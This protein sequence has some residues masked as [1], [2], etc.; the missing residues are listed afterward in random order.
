M[1]RNIW[2]LTLNIILSHYTESTHSSVLLMVSCGIL[3]SM[4]SRQ[5]VLDV[6]EVLLNT[7][8]DTVDNAS[9]INVEQT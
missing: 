6:V 4:Q 3:Y 9:V 2:S 7:R 1:N 8:R 5:T